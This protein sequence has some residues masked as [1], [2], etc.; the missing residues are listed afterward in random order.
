MIRYMIQVKCYKQVVFQ[1]KVYYEEL[2][3]LMGNIVFH[4]PS[5][6]LAPSTLRGCQS[7]LSGK[8]ANLCSEDLPSQH[9]NI[10]WAL[11]LVCD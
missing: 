10:A 2:A 1:G 8:P 3:Q 4:R 9:V 11:S 7:P 5:V 6:I